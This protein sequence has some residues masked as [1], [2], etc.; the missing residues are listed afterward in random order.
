MSNLGIRW[1]IDGVGAAFITRGDANG[2]YCITFEREVASLEQIENIEWSNPVIRR[3]TDYEG[4]LGLPG[5][6]GFELVNICYCHGTRT[7]VAEIKI[8]RQY[9]GDVSGY[10]AQ[11]EDLAHTAAEQS[12]VI[13]EQTT[14]MAAM[15][16]D[17]ESAYEEGVESNG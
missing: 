10:Q 13:Q 7:F 16:S 12:A 15:V 8:G 4:E 5:G 6:Y 17:M 14:K 2:R 3:L 9:L 11:V 1:E